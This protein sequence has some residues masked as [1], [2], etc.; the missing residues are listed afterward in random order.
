MSE[1]FRSGL[2]W[3]GDDEYF[4]GLYVTCWSVPAFGVHRRIRSSKSEF[5]LS[6]LLI[7]TNQPHVCDWTHSKK[8]FWRKFRPHQFS[9]GFSNLGTSLIRSNSIRMARPGRRISRRPRNPSGLNTLY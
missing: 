9:L 7:L 6:D 5:P 3:R 1:D 8:T 2:M 4:N